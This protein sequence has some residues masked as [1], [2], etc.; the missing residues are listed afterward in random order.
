LG[1]PNK[2][3]V[4]SPYKGEKYHLLEFQQGLR[5]SGKKEVPNHLHSSLHNMIERAFDVLKEKWRIM[6]H[7]PSYSMEKQANII[8]ACMTLYNFIRDTPEN[9]DLCHTWF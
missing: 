2:K 7:L 5:P 1:Y 6:K 8:L 3:G 4:L 9:D